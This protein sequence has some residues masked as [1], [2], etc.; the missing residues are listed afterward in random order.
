MNI[1]NQSNVTYNAVEPNKAGVPGSLAS[2]AG[3]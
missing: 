2:N 3:K 1:T